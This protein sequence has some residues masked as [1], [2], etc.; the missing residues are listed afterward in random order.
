MAGAIREALAGH[1]TIRATD[2]WSDVEVE[3]SAS[4]CIVVVVP[5]LR[6]PDVRYHLESVR[7]SAP[8][9]PMVVVT[10]KDAEN[11]QA[12][13][14]MPV[15]E[16]VWETTIRDQLRPAVLRVLEQSYLAVVARNVLR[17]VSLGR[18]VRLAIA[19][20]CRS[21]PPLQ[22][23]D[24]LAMVCGVPRST[25][26]AAWSKAAPPTLTPKLFL[27]WVRLLRAVAGKTAHRSWESIAAELQVDVDTLARDATHVAGLHLRDLSVATIDLLREIFEDSVLRPLGIPAPPAKMR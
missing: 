24:R 20:A 26:N 22:S 6:H 18:D 17:Q 27:R 11:A 3:A 8:D 23:V 12:I 25:L 1:F 19:A 5:G 2:Q 13:A 16:V 15:D 9:T 14:G 4:A 10:T 7:T 21:H